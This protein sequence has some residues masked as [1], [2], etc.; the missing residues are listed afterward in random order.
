M[1]IPTLKCPM[2]YTYTII[3][4]SGFAYCRYTPY[5]HAPV[6]YRDFKQDIADSW[7]YNQFIDIPDSTQLEPA[8]VYKR[9]RTASGAYYTHIPEDNSRYTQE[10]N[11]LHAVHVHDKMNS[12]KP[13][14]ETREFTRSNKE[15]TYGYN[16]P[17]TDK[18]PYAD[19]VTLPQPISVGG[20]RDVTDLFAQT[21]SRNLPQMLFRKAQHAHAPWHAY[22]TF[23]DWGEPPREPKAVA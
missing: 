14:I 23:C 11:A 8:Q 22:M 2:G 18:N 20:H 7:P 9:P 5:K 16:R 6:H 15:I 13:D 3:L 1:I 10:L 19:L 12:G 21:Y 4:K 17:I